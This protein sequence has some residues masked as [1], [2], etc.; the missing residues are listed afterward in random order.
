M[1]ST[2]AQ[3]CSVELPLADGGSENRIF[4]CLSTEFF[5]KSVD[6]ETAPTMKMCC[7]YNERFTLFCCVHT[8]QQLV[9]LDLSPLL[10]NVIRYVRTRR[11]SVKPAYM[12]SCNRFHAHKA[13]HPPSGRVGD[14]VAM[15]QI[16]SPGIGNHGVAEADTCICPW[17]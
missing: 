14:V 3:R 10:R 6:I 15:L 9:L 1:V 8:Y 5:Q 12:R 13:P 11:I 4:H 7:F 16:E 2:S 17:S